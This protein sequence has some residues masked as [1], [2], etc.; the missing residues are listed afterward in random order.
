MDD[1]K[2][3]SLY[4]ARDDSAIKETDIKYGRSLN[5]L[6]YNI[7]ESSE[8]AEECVNDT[9]LR[10]WNS[11]PPTRPAYFFGFLAKITRNLSLNV[12]EKRSA[13]KRSGVVM[14]LNEELSA[15]L[16]ADSRAESVENLYLADVI[17]SFLKSLDYTSK[18]IFMHRYFFSESVAHIAQLTGKS[19][20]AVSSLLFRTR[21]K[22][23][24]YLERE[25][26]NV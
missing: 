8:D 9:Y 7:T 3:I 6:S 5:S 26:I 4:F 22:L 10:T 21:K 17:N 1:E 19:E 12:C 13:E 23:K 15:V 11:I 18:Y 20:N 14:S 16:P 25:G 2:I 24:K